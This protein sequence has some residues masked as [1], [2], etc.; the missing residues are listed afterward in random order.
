MSNID[1]YKLE[2][3]EKW[4]H[5]VKEMPFIQFPDGWKIAVIPPFHGALARFRVEL[6]SGQVKSVYFDA[7]DR[8]GYVGEPYWEVH[9]YRGDCGRCLLAKV[10]ELIALI[11]D[12]SAE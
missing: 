10:D 1:R 11:A 7:H 3:S 2:D 12:E 4:G 8:L 6:P 9:P 5:F